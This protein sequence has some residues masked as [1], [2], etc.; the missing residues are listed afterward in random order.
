MMSEPFVVTEV[1]IHDLA[2]PVVF[3]RGRDYLRQGAVMGLARSEGRVTARVAGSDTEPYRVRVKLGPSGVEEADCTC[4]YDWGGA[5][6]HVVAVLLAC[7]EQPESL[8][9]TPALASR[10]SR[11]DAD[12]LRALLLELADED[13]DVARRIERRALARETKSRVPAAVAA[14][15]DPTP[16]R[17]QARSAM[18][19]GRGGRY[20]DYY[21]ASGAVVSGLYEVLEPVTALIEVGDGR[22]ALVVLEAVTDEFVGALDQLYDH[23]GEFGSL[24]ERLNEWWTEALLTAD[25]TPD[26]R[27]EYA[28]M[29]RFYDQQL[30]AGDY[31][32][33]LEMAAA[34]AEQ[35]W[36]Y[37][38][39]VRVLRGEITDRGAWEGKAPHYADELAEARLNVLERHGRLQEFLHLAEAESQTE[40]FLTMLV[41]VGRV[42]EAV[43][44]GQEWLTQPQEILVLARALHEHGDHE[45]ALQIAEHGLA[46]KPPSGVRGG[47]VG[48]AVPRD[49]EEEEI[50]EWEED[51]RDEDLEGEEDEVDEDEGPFLAARRRSTPY[52]DSYSWPYHR[53]ELARWLRDTAVSLGQP[54]RARSAAMIVMQES[55]SLADYQALQ[56]V[57]G[58]DWP[59]LQSAVLERLRTPVLARRDAAVEIF[60]HEHL[61]DDAIAALEN[62]HLGHALVGRVVDAVLRE[63]PEWAMNA[64]FH[65]ADR[66]IEPGSAPYYSAA[67]EWLGKAREAAAAGDLVA[68][69]EKRLDEIMSRHQRK[70]KLMPLLKALR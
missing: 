42:A 27:R 49:A 2:D 39:L 70:Y 25:L 30:S 47:W 29:L 61:V 12:E 15:L 48:V 59:S 43:E 24:I 69:W 60:L 58:E 8:E 46:L 68:V 35:G 41:R 66:I 40:R 45:L 57:A 63:R 50:D 3:A 23:D 14:P 54:A 7:M 21:E 38:P 44:K 13:D 6:K 34:A 10:L 64:C 16:Y 53:A 31:D 5:C 62:G 51:E 36:D 55:P 20:D 52:E 28:R 37:P 26:E 22:N 9:E 11:L 18:R 4:P 19:M 56:S 65:Q 32:S 67:A 33:G 17:R 1:M